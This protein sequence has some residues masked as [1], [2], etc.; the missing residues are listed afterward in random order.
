MRIPDVP[1]SGMGGVELPMH[2]FCVCKAIGMDQAIMSRFMTGK[3]GLSM[4]NLDALDRCIV[5]AFSGI[6]LYP[7]TA[8]AERARAQGVIDVK[9]SRTLLQPA[10]ARGRAAVRAM[11]VVRDG[12]IDILFGWWWR[13]SSDPACQGALAGGASS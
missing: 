12:A 13:L 1:V 7:G 8:I 9:V 3:G 4:A 2:P 6:R 5:F 10:V 11:M